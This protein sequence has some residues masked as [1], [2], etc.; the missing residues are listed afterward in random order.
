VQTSSRRTSR[1][2]P[3][4]LIPPP[5]CRPAGAKP[6]A[7]AWRIIRAGRASAGQGSTG[8]VYRAAHLP[9]CAPG[10]PSLPFFRCIST[11]TA[12][13][14]TAVCVGHSSVPQRVGNAPAT[15]AAKRRGPSIMPF[16]TPRRPPRRCWLMS[17]AGACW[18][19]P[20]VLQRKELTRPKHR[21]AYW[22][23]TISRERA[24]FV[25][26][27]RAP[28]RLHLERDPSRVATHTKSGKSRQ[29]L[30]VL[31]GSPPG[32]RAARATAVTIHHRQK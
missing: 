1:G 16:W 22:P 9:N 18:E 15:M 4:V 26:G 8:G 6:A 7:L 23:R 13:D 2:R 17:T 25:R 21:L 31:V 14:S 28:P 24:T 29:C 5:D 20:A 12:L 11:A 3:S 27:L 19:S 10:G 30:T 32:S